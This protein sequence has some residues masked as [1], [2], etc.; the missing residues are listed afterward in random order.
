VSTATTH[1]AR[2]G[3]AVEFLVDGGHAA[4]F[5]HLGR[6]LGIWEELSLPAAFAVTEPDAQ[7][8]VTRAGAPTGPAPQAPV[9]IIDRMAPTPATV[10]SRLHAAGRRVVLVDDVGTGRSTADVVIDPPSGDPWPAPARRALG[11]FEHVLLRREIREARDAPRAKHVLLAIGGS[12]PAGLTPALTAALVE[13]GV[14]VMYALGPGYRGDPPR[15]GRP[16]PPELE[17]PRALAAASLYVGGFGHSLFESAYL[18]SPAVSV[19]FAQ[20]HLGDATRFMRH[21]TA[22][23]VD[24]TDGRTPEPVVATVCS[25]LDRPDRLDAM[26]AA[27]RA[28]VDGHGAERVAHAI[29]GLLEG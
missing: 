22:V 6:C 14:D 16:V 5:G 4:G 21:G 18:G 8:F 17:W 3:A 26:A 9:A 13:A 2:A 19:V 20:R 27:G 29:E 15:T 12:D 1:G 10:V 24:M 7:R 23:V 25:L 28:L 11:G